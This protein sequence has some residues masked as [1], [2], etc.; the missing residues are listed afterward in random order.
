MKALRIIL[1][2]AVFAIAT[3]A[4][5][6]LRVAW[7]MTPA[8]SGLGARTIEGTVWNG[9]ITGLVWSGIELGDFQ[10]SA[11]LL[12]I[13]PSPA[14]R[15][16]QGA[17]FLKR[18]A[19]RP[20]SG[21]LSISDLELRIPL[22][23]LDARLPP[24]SDLHITD[25]EANLTGSECTHAAGKIRA[26]PAPQLGLTELAGALSCDAGELLATFA[27]HTGSRATVVI[28]LDGRTPPSVRDA[29]PD[30]TLTLAAFGIA[31]S[32]DAAE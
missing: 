30:L 25:G 28:P 4:M 9:R 6:P 10:T 8:S 17:G 19:L 14:V 15:L 1:P 27:T 3:V 11:S 7:A 20:G 13:L 2:L 29:T 5:L 16:D 32:R 23:M 31:T 18:A 21:T 26:D 12:E 22:S 24:T